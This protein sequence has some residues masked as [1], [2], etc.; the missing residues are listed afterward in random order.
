MFRHRRH[1]NTGQPGS[2]VCAPG[3]PHLE[4]HPRHSRGSGQSNLFLYSASQI[5]N[6]SYCNP[7]P[8]KD[9]TA[10]VAETITIAVQ[11]TRLDWCDPL[12]TSRPG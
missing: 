12:A 2:R 11:L 6:S 7:E 4:P 3:Q 1:G 9:V 5:R 8:D 10:I